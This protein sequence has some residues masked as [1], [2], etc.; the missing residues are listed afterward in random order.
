MILMN[1]TLEANNSGVLERILKKNSTSKVSEFPMK[2]LCIFTFLFYSVH[3]A[4]N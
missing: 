4:V 3:V 1:D 2:L